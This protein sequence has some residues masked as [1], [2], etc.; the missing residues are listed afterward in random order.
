[1]SLTETLM[2][3]ALG[4]ALALLMV[5]LFGRGFWAIATNF[6]ARRKAKNIPIQMLE[7]QA[8]RDRL[9]AEHAIMARQL[10]LRLEDIKARM[11]EQMAEVSRSRNRMQTLIEQLETSEATVA[12]RDRE[13]AGL[14]AQVEAYRSDLETVTASLNNLTFDNSQK[15]LEITKLNQSVS[16]LKLGLREKNSMVARLAEES[17]TNL[18]TRTAAI[19]QPLKTE[20]HE[21]EVGDGRIKKRISELTSISMEMDETQRS[22]IQNSDEPVA[23]IAPVEITQFKPDLKTKFV[24]A[25]RESDSL[26][27][28]LKSIDEALERKR[29]SPYPPPTPVKSSAKANI[30]SLAQRIR[31]LQ[32]DEN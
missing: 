5:L 15:N 32:S 25:E 26:S 30:I 20:I 17:K 21:T 24:D 11:T 4:F 3:V 12:N 29:N 1:M 16:Q 7:L 22:N 10:E 8:D 23:D 6:G 2:L 27:Q 13:I 31:A 19:G 18:R 14:M 28:E 9:R